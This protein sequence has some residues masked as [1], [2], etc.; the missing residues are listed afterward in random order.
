[1]KSYYDIQGDGGS[2]VAGQVG[3][4]HRAVGEALSGVRRLIAIGSGKGGVGKSTTALGLARALTRAGRSVTILDADLNG[5]CQA[6]L[7]GLGG[8]PWVPEDGRLV[9][10]RRDDGIGVASL[11]SVLAGGGTIPFETVSE[12]EGHVWRATREFAMLMQLLA[13]VRWGEVDVLLADLPPG[14]ERTAHFADLFGGLAGDR[15]AF[16]L[17][18]IPSALSRG[19]VARSVAALGETGVP[20]LGIV[21]NMAGYY[22]RGCGGVRPLFPGGGAATSG[23]QA[24][25]DESLG[26]LLGRVPFDPGV[27]ALADRGWPVEGETELATG[28][29]GALAALD[30][31][32]ERL[33]AA[34]DAHF[35]A[36]PAGGDRPPIEDPR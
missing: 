15:C 7:A 6:Q 16:A 26:P 29:G 34:F 2:D 8:A 1:M 3:E 32:A 9:L 18:T 13:T 12:G 22:C 36:A 11:G 17:V 5:P 21:E 23:E 20:L 10:P 19:V 28:D 35:R 30:A 27:A 4:L 14:A 33:L 24:P 25:G 31:V